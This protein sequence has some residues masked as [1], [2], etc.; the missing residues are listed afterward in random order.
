MLTVSL[1]AYRTPERLDGDNQWQCSDE[2]DAAKVDALKGV[3]R[4]FPKLAV[5]P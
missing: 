1:Q 2:P 5:Y 3:H 4:C